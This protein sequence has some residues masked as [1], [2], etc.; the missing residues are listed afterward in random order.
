MYVELEQSQ[1]IENLTKEGRLNMHWMKQNQR[2]LN[3]K[4]DFQSQTL[5]LKKKIIRLSQFLMES[6]IVLRVE[7][8][9]LVRS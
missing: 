3:Q 4:K 6:L 5:H 1:G 7:K 8:S 2:Y 9:F